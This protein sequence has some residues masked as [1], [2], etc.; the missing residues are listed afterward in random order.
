MDIT[1]NSTCKK[2]IFDWKKKLFIA[3]SFLG[4]I[5][6]TN[7]TSNGSDENCISYL[8]AK[9][10]NVSFPE[11]GQVN[12]SIPI[13][14]S[15]Q[16]INGCGKFGSIEETNNGKVKSLKVI[17]KYEGCICTQ[18]LLVLNHIYDFIAIDTGIYTVN[19]LQPDG[20][21]ISKSITIH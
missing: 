8:H 10:E 4:L 11:F 20:V 9:V 14:I 21:I 7:C 13:N 6:T 15:F 5:L 2:N 19:F 3:I 18:E 1:M 16:C 17:S 12:K